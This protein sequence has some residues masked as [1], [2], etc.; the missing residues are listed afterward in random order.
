MCIFYTF[1]ETIVYCLV[2]LEYPWILSK[3]RI[4]QKSLDLRILGYLSG[5]FPLLTLY[6]FTYPWRARTTRNHT[7]KITLFLSSIYQLTKNTICPLE[8]IIATPSYSELL[9]S[10]HRYS[11][12]VSYSTL[13]SYSTLLA[14]QSYPSL[15]TATHRYSPLRSYSTLLIVTQE[16]AL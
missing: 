14:T 8:I 7:F 10:T 12:L 16:C 13:P 2:W 3:Q 4:S 5:K 1:Q 11:T 9:L 6:G 15:L